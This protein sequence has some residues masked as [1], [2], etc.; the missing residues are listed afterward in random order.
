MQQRLIFAEQHLEDRKRILGDYNIQCDVMLIYVK[1]LTGKTVTLEAVSADSIK[2]VKQMLQKKEGIPPDQQRLI[3]AGKQLQDHHTLGYYHIQ[4]ESTIHIVLRLR[5]GMQ[6]FVKTVAG[7][8]IALE[9][10]PADSI[11]NVKQKVCDKVGI[12]AIQQRL[13]FASKELKND[14]TLSDYN[15][16]KESSLHLVQSFSTNV[17]QI[18][19]ESSFA[20]T[21]TFLV[22][23]TEFVKNIKQKIQKK[24]KI[25]ADQQRLTYSGLIL[26]DGRRLCKY[27]ITTD[28]TITLAHDFEISVR[29]TDNERIT[30]A[31]EGVGLKLALELRIDSRTLKY[32]CEFSSESQRSS[33]ILE[34]SFTEQQELSLR[35]FQANVAAAIPKK[36]KLVG[37]ELDLEMPT[38]RTI[39]T[40]TQNL[41]DRFIEVFDHWQKNPTPQRPFCWD[42]V[43][44]VL[45]S[46]TINEP[47]LARKISQQF[48]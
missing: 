3:F 1:S 15:V 45:K 9:V 36:W 11:E 34:T 43:V 2:Y 8:T 26:E 10:D 27:N 42:T 19:V 28:S 5:G 44:K 32:A 48:C 13:T 35:L 22:T 47:E 41:Q 20:E 40:E 39:E 33:S 23:K 14:R 18:F 25:P 30:R 6:I 31:P 21:L 4:K 17:L 12:P 37:I 7:K 46:P 38:I 16:P 24:T 29:F